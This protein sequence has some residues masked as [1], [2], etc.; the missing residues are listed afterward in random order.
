MPSINMIAARRAEKKKQEQHVKSLA[1]AVLAEIGLVF[2]AISILSLRLMTTNARA[3]TLD[4]QLSK[5]EPKVIQI[6]DL[7]SKIAAITPKVAMLA[8]AKADTM[9]W[10]NGVSDISSCLS[11]KTWLTGLST[12]TASTATGFGGPGTAEANAPTVSLLGSAG[13]PDM[14]G[15][16]ILKLN[17]LPSLDKVEL[18]FVQHQQIGTVDAVTFQMNVYLKPEPAAAA[19]TPAVGG[20]DAVKS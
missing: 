7:Q 19:A 12:A 20:S 16:T 15:D 2:L 14:V 17:T 1:Y 18:A 3:A 8:G 11:G 5:L 4:G 13:N 10:Y 6:H 9:F